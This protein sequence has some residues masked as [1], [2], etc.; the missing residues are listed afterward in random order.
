MTDNWITTNT[1]LET[2]EIF[3][4][5]HCNAECSEKELT[6]ENKLSL[7]GDC[8]LSRATCIVCAKSFVEETSNCYCPKCFDELEEDYE[9]LQAAQR[10]ELVTV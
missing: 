7:C 2:E 9:A 3:N 5:V 10:D 8:E 4:C 1:A 6:T